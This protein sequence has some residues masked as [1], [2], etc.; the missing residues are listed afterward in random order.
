MGVIA[1]SVVSVIVV[2]GCCCCLG[3]V[4][5]DKE[6]KLNTLYIHFRTFIKQ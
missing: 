1:C 5:Y 4:G 6:T 2:D 3:D